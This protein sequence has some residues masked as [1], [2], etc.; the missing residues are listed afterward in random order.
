MATVPKQTAGGAAAGS[1]ERKRVEEAPDADERRHHLS[2]LR[3][4]RRQVWR[5]EVLQVVWQ[6]LVVW[7]AVAVAATTTTG[8]APPSG[9]LLWSNVSEAGFGLLFAGSAVQVGES[10]DVLLVG[11]SASGPLAINRMHATTGEIVW[12]LALKAAGLDKGLNSAVSLATGALFG[13]PSTPTLVAWASS[14]EDTVVSG[15]DI[16]SGDSQWS[17]SLPFDEMGH[18]I[19]SNGVFLGFGR[20]RNGAA[21]LAYAI[22]GKD[23]NG[24]EL[25]F[26]VS[27]GSQGE[28]CDSHRSKFTCVR[29]SLQHDSAPYK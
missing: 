13:E 27:I 15:V 2:W 20:R 19:F 26:N 25:L 23:D 11:P 24:A 17:L 29:D 3:K 22:S 21:A 7:Q 8:A 16:E 5:G 6:A 14:L 10:G 18:Y 1:R 4:R 28:N 12:S 9:S